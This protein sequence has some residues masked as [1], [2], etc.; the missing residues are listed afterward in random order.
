MNIEIQNKITAWMIYKN[1]NSLRN[2]EH[3]IA[4]KEIMRLQQLLECEV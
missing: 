2:S 4:T 3:L 1:C